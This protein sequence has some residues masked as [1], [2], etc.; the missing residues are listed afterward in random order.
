ME[1]SWPGC[2]LG[3]DSETFT[4]RL[5]GD[6]P[7]AIPL[8]ELIG[9]TVLPRT[10]PADGRASATEADAELVVGWRSGAARQSLLIPVPREALQ[11][12]L[13]LARLAQLR[14]EADLRALPAKEALARLGVAD[15]PARRRKGFLVLLAAFLL[16]L[17]II[18]EG[19]CR[20]YEDEY[21]RSA[22]SDGGFE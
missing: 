4:V 19:D 20:R 15:P 13:F 2:S 12:Q 3:L 11:V 10:A 8:A 18:V 16:A 5:G 22:P 14:P 6:A 1:A 21:R 17:A 7:V 9:F